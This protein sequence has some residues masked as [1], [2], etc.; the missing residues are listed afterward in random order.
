M[1]DLIKHVVETDGDT[2]T[3]INCRDPELEGEPVAEV[4]VEWVPDAQRL[5]VELS[6]PTGRDVTAL[7]KLNG[8]EV[9]GVTP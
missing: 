1:T 4:V 8:V 9:I 3:I 2:D 5:I 7:V 6:A